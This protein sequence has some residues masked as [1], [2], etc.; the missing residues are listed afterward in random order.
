M[1]REKVI[2]IHA[3]AY[4]RTR[5]GSLVKN[6]A[7]FLL[8]SKKIPLISCGRGAKDLISAKRRR[9]LINAREPGGRVR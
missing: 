8:I 9:L 2:K 5:P 3:R 4:A 6:S 1:D 7:P